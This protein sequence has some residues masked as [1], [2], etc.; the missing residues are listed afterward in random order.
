MQRC[1]CCMGTECGP[2]S[3]G[4]PPGWPGSSTSSPS[5]AA[6][7]VR[8]CRGRR[9]ATGDGTSHVHATRTDTRTS[10]THPRDHQPR[11]LPV[12]YAWCG[13]R[14]CR[15][16]VL[17]VTLPWLRSTT[18]GHATAVRHCRPRALPHQGDQA[19]AQLVAACKGLGAWLTCL[20]LVCVT[21]RPTA[22]LFRL[23]PILET[24]VLNAPV[25]VEPFKGHTHGV[26][27]RLLA[28]AR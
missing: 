22:A 13:L 16:G 7:F 10:Q 21:G 5:T 12:A 4:D 14:V 17:A 27:S 28:T 25:L 2:G 6:A 3:A 8:A 18:R 1:S 24:L 9:A 20:M 26:D 23:R 11:C 15:R 19:Q